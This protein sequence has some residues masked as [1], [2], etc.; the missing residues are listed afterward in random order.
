MTKL[1]H[2]DLF[3][4]IGGFS[5]GLE[6]TNGFETVA[7]CEI[8]PFC[9][10]VLKKH[11]PDVPIHEDVRSLDYDGTIDIITGGFPCQDLSC[12][13]KQA[14]I[15]GEKSGLWGFMFKHIGKLRPKYVIVENVTALLSGDS[16]KWF[17]RLLSDLASIRYGAEWHCIRACA[18]GLPHSRNRVWI[19]AYPNEI[20]PANNR[21]F[22]NKTAIRDSWEASKPI[23]GNPSWEWLLTN[24][25]MRDFRKDNGL[26]QAAHRI[27]AL[28]NSIIPQIPEI[29]G[30]AILEAE[31]HVAS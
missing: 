8:D 7:F 21:T 17:G 27:G 25:D 9:Q 28:G 2:L 5:L 4:G 1:K 14:G 18:L 24:G 30:H 15:D 16:G 6:R 19:I 3:S 11:W 22:L 10:K 29:I 31:C 20:R 13:G 12:A 23:V 26:P